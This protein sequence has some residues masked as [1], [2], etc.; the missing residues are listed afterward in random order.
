MKLWNA[1][2]VLVAV[3]GALVTAL[4]I[5]I[6]TGIIVT[7]FYTRMTP[8]QWWNYPVWAVSSVLAGAVIA[9]YVRADSA[10]RPHGGKALGG[11]VLSLLAVGCP[12]C[13]KLVVFALGAS[14][15]MT[16]FA[17]AQPLLAVASLALLAHAFRARLRAERECALPALRI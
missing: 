2:R 3:V 9:T 15:T 10:T 4:L 16:W 1:P 17:P 12:I 7:S 11:S 8:V 6:P 5:G 13:N 14:G